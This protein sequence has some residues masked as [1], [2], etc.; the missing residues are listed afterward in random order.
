VKLNGVYL[1]DESIPFSQSYEEG[2]TVEF[3]YKNF[4][5]SFAPPGTYGLTF[6]FKNKDNKDNGCM[7]FSFKL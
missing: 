6:Q 7:A 1:H 4:V 3:R 5:P 2:D